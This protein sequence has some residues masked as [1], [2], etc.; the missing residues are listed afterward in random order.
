[1]FSSTQR[2]F[3]SVPELATLPVP[4]SSCARCA[5]T[6]Q[7]ELQCPCRS[8]RGQSA[9]L[10]QESVSSEVEPNEHTHCAIIAAYSKA[11][12]LTEAV[13]HFQE[14]NE[15]MALPIEGNE[16]RQRYTFLSSFFEG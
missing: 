13:C 5:T 1:M 11:G 4:R 15:E 10:K 2:R 8:L 16:H 3:H 6:R 7:A 9:D 14:A 12:R